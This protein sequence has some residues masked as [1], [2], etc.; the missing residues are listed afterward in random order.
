MQTTAC[1]FHSRS[2]VVICFYSFFQLSLGS[3]LAAQL[4]AD[5]DEMLREKDEQIQ[6]LTRMLRQ[7]QKLVEALKMQLQRGGHPGCSGVTRM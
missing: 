3:R 1:L 2:C 4:P 7:E 6:E 5:K